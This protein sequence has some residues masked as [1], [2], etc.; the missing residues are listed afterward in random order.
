MREQGTAGSP[1]PPSNAAAPYGPCG[2]APTEH[3]VSAADG[4]AGRRAALSPDDTDVLPLENY[5]GE[6]LEFTQEK[7]ASQGD[8]QGKPAQLDGAVA[9]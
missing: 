2:I 4:S 9:H 7:N 8:S 5:F 6:L 3:E 1:R